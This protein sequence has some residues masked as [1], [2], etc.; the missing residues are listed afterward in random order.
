MKKIL[1]ELIENEWKFRLKYIE[2]KKQY[3]FSFR[4]VDEFLKGPNVISFIFNEKGEFIETEAYIFYL[5]EDRTL[6]E[7]KEEHIE[8][9]MF[10]KGEM[11]Y[12]IKKL[13]FSQYKERILFRKE[14]Y[15]P[16]YDYL[17]INFELDEAIYTYHL[18]LNNPQKKVLECKYIDPNSRYFMTVQLE[19]IPSFKGMWEYVLD[20]PEIRVKFV[21]QLVGYK[22]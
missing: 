12:L 7:T 8:E 22:N 21:N 9:V 4:Y 14:D 10:F 13:L 1:K 5:L 18:E 3:T 15:L 6:E 17:G 19:N 2:E 16:Q 20:H 11:E